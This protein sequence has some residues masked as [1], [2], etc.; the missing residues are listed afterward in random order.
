MV[1][2]LVD[3]YYSVVDQT[4]H[5]V[6]VVDQNRHFVAVVDQTHRFVVQNR[7]FGQTHQFVVVV[8]VVD[9]NHQTRRFVVVVD[10]TRRLVECCWLRGI[11]SS[12]GMRGK[13][14]GMRRGIMVIMM[15]IGDHDDDDHDGWRTLM[16]IITSRYGKLFRHNVKKTRI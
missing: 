6:V 4:R 13:G 9:R 11:L 3:C 16:M 5:F 8:V 10:Q 12:D 2:A 15:T 14:E 7:Q 1:I